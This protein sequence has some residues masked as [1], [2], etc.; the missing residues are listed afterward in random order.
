MERERS[1]IYDIVQRK[2]TENLELEHYEKDGALVIRRQLSQ[3][4]R[5]FLV[6]GR[7]EKKIIEGCYFVT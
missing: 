5:L 6:K 7:T 1:S 2:L 4:S 3:F